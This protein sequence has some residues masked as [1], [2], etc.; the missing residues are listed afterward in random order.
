A[1]LAVLHTP[2]HAPGHVALHD[3]ERNVVL[4]GDLVSGLSTILVG[5]DDGDMG[6]YLAS[7]RRVG[8]L[9]CRAVLPAHGPPLPAS[10]SIDMIAHR[11]AR[12]T[13][14]AGAL[15]AHSRTLSALAEEA[16]R[17]TPDAPRSL[18]EMQTL[19]H[20]RRLENMGQ[21]KRVASDGRAWT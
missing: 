8:S 16:Y 7:L 6:L 14:I 9:R 1:S 19:S 3:A 15:A 18:R 4:T 5:P 11:E 12:E 13:R 17:D 21:A 10:A 20:L 2:G